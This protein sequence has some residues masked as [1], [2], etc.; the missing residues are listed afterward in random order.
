MKLENRSAPAPVTYRLG[1]LFC[2]PGGLALGALGS[3]SDDGSQRVEH[4]WAND[5]DAD[6]CETYRHNISP[7]SPNTVYLGDVRDLD[8]SSLGAID[9][10]AYGFPCNSFSHV[11]ER[12]GFA[13]EKFGQL[14]WYGVEVLR[15]YQPKWFIAENVSGIR[16]AGSGDFQTILQDLADSGYKL[17]THLYKSEL[18]GVPQTRHRVIIVGIRSD[19]DV[20]Y[21]VPDPARWVDAD[22]SARTALSNIP[23][24]APNNE[25]RQLS[26]TVTRRLSY[27]RP[28]ENVWQ[29]ADRL[30]KDFPDELRIN[31]K[32]RISQI[33][34]KLNP[35]KPAYT[36]TAAGGG[37]TF[38]YHWTDR[39]LT[40]R[41]R[42]RLQTFPDDFAFIGKYAS[43]RKQI[44][45]AVPPQLAQVVTTGILN[46]FA[47]IPYPWIEANL[48]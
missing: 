24:D 31:T 27:I 44:G 17:T 25:V 46:S 5:Y 12:Q 43:V 16:S 33:Y 19:L 8:L 11:G 14:Y 1:E 7:Q 37:G 3:T 39:E 29:A 28:G 6:T 35:N 10:F 2:G 41:E 26:E 20:T 45:M 40:N 23:V 22:I 4:A 36:V 9:A 42:A 13:N 15:M 18:Y 21:Q 38:M 32:T 48:R 30:G 34:R 47:G